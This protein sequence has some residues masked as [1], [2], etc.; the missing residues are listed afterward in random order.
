M[1]FKLPG[2]KLNHLH[3]LALRLTLV[4]M[5]TQL[6]SIF[7]VC[8]LV[9]RIHQLEGVMEHFFFNLK[10]RY[11]GL[12]EKMEPAISNA[13]GVVWEQDVTKSC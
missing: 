12:E 8:L 6:P 4:K 11:T 5:I 10:S 9:T 7:P 2:S 1:V 13:T 3:L